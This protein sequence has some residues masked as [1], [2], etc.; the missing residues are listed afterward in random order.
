MHRSSLRV[1]YSGRHLLC[2]NQRLQF[3]WSD[4]SLNKAM[5]LLLS[6]FFEILFDKR[7]CLWLIGMYFQIR[8]HFWF[9]IIIKFVEALH[10]HSGN[11]L[12]LENIRTRQNLTI[13]IYQKYLLLVIVSIN[14]FDY[15]IK[16]EKSNVPSTVRHVW[17]S[18]NDF[19]ND[20]FAVLCCT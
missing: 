16:L 11:N 3:P 9:L 1:V 8:R 13:N 15:G 17:K 4:F 6:C 2:V 12:L 19:S 20:F 5:P 10:P 7:L 18:I 14:Y